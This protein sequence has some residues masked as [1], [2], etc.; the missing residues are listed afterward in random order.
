MFVCLFVCLHVCVHAY[1]LRCS[2]ATV[3]STYVYG[4]SVFKTV[5]SDGQ[6]NKLT[7]LIRKSGK[8]IKKMKKGARD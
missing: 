7:V 4:S 6:R 5:P 2:N 8:E 3:V 1:I